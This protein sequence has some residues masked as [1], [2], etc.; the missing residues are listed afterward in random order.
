MG[1]HNQDIDDWGQEP[2]Q[3]PGSYNFDVAGTE[4]GTLFLVGS[5]L[6]PYKFCFSRTQCVVGVRKLI[7]IFCH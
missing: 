3:E 5:W 2:K 6:R 4:P 1:G 7:Q